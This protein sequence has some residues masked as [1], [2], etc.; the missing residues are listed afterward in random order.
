LANRQQP[1]IQESHWDSF[2]QSHFI[3]PWRFTL[4]R[5]SATFSREKELGCDW[6]STCV[7]RC[8]AP[9]GLVDLYHRKSRG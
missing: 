1:D 5:P 8:A 9:A 6:P 2:L 3:L 7:W 4:I